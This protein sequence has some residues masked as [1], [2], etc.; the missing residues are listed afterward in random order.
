[1]E[2][3]RKLARARQE[4]ESAGQRA[5]LADSQEKTSIKRRLV[6]L[7]NTETDI[8]AKRVYRNAYRTIRV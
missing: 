4:V 5:L 8:N 6:W 7:A 2:L 3:L 1:V